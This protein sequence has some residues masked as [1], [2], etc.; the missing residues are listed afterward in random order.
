MFDDDPHTVDQC[1]EAMLAPVRR[2][3]QEGLQPAIH[4]RVSS[5]RLGECIVAALEVL[6]VVSPPTERPA[7]EVI[8]C[9]TEADRQLPGLIMPTGNS[10][11]P[12]HTALARRHAQQ[13]RSGA[14]GAAVAD[15]VGPRKSPG[16]NIRTHLYFY[17]QPCPLKNGLPDGRRIAAEYAALFQAARQHRCTLVTL[18]ILSETLA[19]KSA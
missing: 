16:S 13:A 18:E 10:A 1:V 4:I 2:C 17:A 14:P 5:P 3:Y 12:M 11:D 7:M 9:L 6:P 19:M 15:R 8:D